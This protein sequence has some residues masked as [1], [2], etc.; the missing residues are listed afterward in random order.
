LVAEFENTLPPF[1]NRTDAFEVQNIADNLNAF[2]SGKYNA[3]F[4]APPPPAPGAQP[5]PD[6]RFVMGIII[7]GYSRG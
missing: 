3:Q 1:R 2:I 7:G 4:P 6:L 5:M